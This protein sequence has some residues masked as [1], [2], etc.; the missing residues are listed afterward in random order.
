M[1]KM[2]KTL[3]AIRLENELNN[4]KKYISSC[5][6]VIE[7][8]VEN[9]AGHAE[10]QK[11]RLLKANKECIAHHKNYIKS[12]EQQ[13][14]DL[15]LAGEVDVEL[16]DEYYTKCL[17]NMN[18]KDKWE[19]NSIIKHFDSDLIPMD[20]GYFGGYTLITFYDKQAIVYVDDRNAIVNFVTHFYDKI[21]YGGR[22]RWHGDT[23]FGCENRP[24]V[25][26]E[27]GKYNMVCVG[28]KLVFNEWYSFIDPI[29]NY[30]S[31]VGHYH[32]AKDMNGA[33]I[34]LSN[35]G[36]VVKDNS[37]EMAFAKSLT[38]EEIL[39][40]WINAGKLVVGGF[41]FQYRGAGT[42]VIDNTTAAKNFH[43]YHFSM[44]YYELSWVEYK[45][46]VALSMR[47]YSEN[48]LM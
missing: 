46:Q 2:A 22:N 18:G 6:E 11:E 28:N 9:L 27:N 44:G 30:S 8:L 33:T 39:E 25:V 16:N 4:E 47:E 13:L 21:C 43:K 41:G 42:G 24:I 3:K 48:D 29:E 38:R 10:E 40:K 23:R 26:I 15:K 34:K 19:I 5:E 20:N 45:G 12:L 35:G 32:L 31:A 36:Y 14:E 7:S 1:A 17:N 37:A